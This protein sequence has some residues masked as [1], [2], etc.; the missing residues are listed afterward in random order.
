MAKNNDNQ[1]RLFINNLEREDLSSSSVSNPKLQDLLNSSSEN[2][3][4]YLEQPDKK[5][6]NRS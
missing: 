6:F 4:I 3:K 1:Q 5:Y 2:T